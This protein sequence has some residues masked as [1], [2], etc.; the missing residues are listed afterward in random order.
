MESVLASSVV[1]TADMSP[2][3]PWSLE[4]R[5]KESGVKQRE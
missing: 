5:A 2:E 1:H 4:S 3:R